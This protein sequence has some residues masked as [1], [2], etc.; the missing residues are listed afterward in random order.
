MVYEQQKHMYDNRLRSH[1]HRIVSISQPHV[2]P[3]VRGKAGKAVEF[4]AKLSASLNNNGLAH[5]DEVRWEAFNESADLPGQVEAFKK[6]HG[7][8]PAVVLADGIYGTRENRR[9]CKEKGI[10]FG[11]KPLGRPRKETDANR[12]E[13]REAKR[14]H[15]R[16]H[17]ERI[18]IEGKLFVRFFGIFEL[19]RGRVFGFG[20]YSF[21][22]DNSIFGQ[23]RA[24]LDQGAKT[25][26][27]KIR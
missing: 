16:D 9:Y 2:R 27:G 13:L 19:C 17:L 7:Y 4:G 24:F 14:Q 26:Q 10:R 25:V 12:E 21:L 6:R 15:R 23:C 11:G 5:V 18:P 1:P 22:K 3:I 8:Y 20:R